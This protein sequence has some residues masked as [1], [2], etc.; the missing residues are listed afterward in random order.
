MLKKLTMVLLVAVLASCDKKDSGK[1]SNRV[2][3]EIFASVGFRFLKQD[4]S[5]IIVKN[6]SVVNQ[7]TKDT[8]TIKDTGTLSI[9]I[10]ELRAPGYYTVIN[11]S[12]KD[13]LTE[14][15]IDLKVSGTDS[16]HNQTKT[17]IVK[18][19]VDE[20]GCHVKKISGP[21]EIKFDN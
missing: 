17:A 8:I 2:C 14:A 4:G 7:Q 3:T 21:D 16:L 13:K 5:G 9:G 20:C 19:G 11:D 12:Y 15:G 10:N 1:C 6:Y 18:V